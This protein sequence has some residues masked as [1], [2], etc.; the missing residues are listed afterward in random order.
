MQAQ[1]LK[2]YFMKVESLL[3]IFVETQWG[4]VDRLCKFCFEKLD[5]IERSSIPKQKLKKMPKDNY[6][7][8]ERILKFRFVTA[9]E[10]IRWKVT[11]SETSNFTAANRVPEN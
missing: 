9:L 8:G 1:K 3:R 6:V 4:N 2:L 7:H 10:F 11:D 5:K